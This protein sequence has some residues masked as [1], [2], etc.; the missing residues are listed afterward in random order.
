MNTVNS[1]ES[2]FALVIV[3]HKTILESK[4]HGMKE[5]SISNEYTSLVL[6]TIVI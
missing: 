5:W 2:K 1:S 4:Q 3:P 6:K